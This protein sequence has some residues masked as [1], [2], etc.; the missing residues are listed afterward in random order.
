MSEETGYLFTNKRA[1]TGE[2]IIALLLSQP[3]EIL[4]EEVALITMLQVQA[5]DEL[6]IKNIETTAKGDIGQDSTYKNEDARKGAL[7]YRLTKDTRYQNLLLEVQSRQEEIDQARI[8]I[9]Y[10]RDMLRSYQIIGGMRE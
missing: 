2:D 6:L 3:G 8:H 7:V 9:Q 5:T 4:K 1:Y 10:Q